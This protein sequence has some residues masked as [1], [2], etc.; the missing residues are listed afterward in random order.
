MA[1]ADRDP[2]IDRG[3]VSRDAERDTRP[4]LLNRTPEI[5]ARAGA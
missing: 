5:L 3:P 4:E 1:T 2:G